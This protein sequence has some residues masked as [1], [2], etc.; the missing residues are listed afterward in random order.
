MANDKADAFV[1]D[2]VGN[3]DGLF[4]VAGVVKHNP[5]ELAAVHAASL[6]DL[7]N[8]HLGANEL[9]VAVLGDRAGDRAGQRNLDGVGCQC[10]GAGTCQGCCGNHLGKCFFVC[11]FHVICSL[12]LLFRSRVGSYFFARECKRCV[13][14]YRRSLATA[15]P[16]G[17][18]GVSQTGFV[19][20]NCNIL[21]V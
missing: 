5:F 1:D 10:T 13:E 19:S 14:L 4:R 2:T 12:V 20:A 8:G 17:K 6:V 21:S 7:L 11:H 18:A 16:A 3:R 15:E 9:H